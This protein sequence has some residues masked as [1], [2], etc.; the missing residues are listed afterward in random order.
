MN[1]KHPAD[2]GALAAYVAGGGLAGV[3]GLLAVI[4]PGHSTIYGATGV[5]LVAVAG[6]VRV[7]FNPTPAVGQQA[8]PT[9]PVGYVANGVTPNASAPNLIVPPTVSPPSPTKEP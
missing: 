3:A 4:D 5:A 7:W 8:A 2:I 9:V 1:G 6:F